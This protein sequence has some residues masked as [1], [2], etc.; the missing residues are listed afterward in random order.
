MAPPKSHNEDRALAHEL[1]GYHRKHGPVF[2]RMEDIKSALRKSAT[3]RGE[4]FKEEFAGEGAVKVAGEK[5]GEFK[6]LVPTV[7]PDAF[8]GLSERRRQTLIDQGIVT[9]AENRGRKFYGS[10]KVDVF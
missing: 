10:V 8:L 1:L 5:D 4:N 3:E 2:A 7:V 6:G 9:M